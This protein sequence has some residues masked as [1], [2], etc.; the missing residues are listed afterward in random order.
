MSSLRRILSTGLT[1]GREVL[2]SPR[3]R[4]AAEW[5]MPGGRRSDWAVLALVV[6]GVAWSS[7]WLLSKAHPWTVNDIGK[8]ADNGSRKY[9][10]YLAPG[11]WLGSLLHILAWSPLLLFVRWWPRGDAARYAV[12]PR[13]LRPERRAMDPRLFWS[14]LG[15]ILILAA[16]PRWERLGLSYWGDEGWAVTKYSHG[17]WRPEKRDDFQGPMRFWETRWEQAIFDDHTGG[18]HVGFSVA[19]RI[20][21]DAWRAITGRP[22]QD[23][24]ET[25]SRLPS[26]LGGLSSLV[27]LALMF[28]WRGMARTGLV[29]AALLALHPM[30]LR[31]SSEARGYGMMIAL[32][33]FTIWMALIALDTGRWRWWLL[34]GLGECLTMI[35]WRGISYGLVCLNLLLLGMLIFGRAR[36]DTQ[37]LPKGARYVAGGRWLAANLLAG[38]CFLHLSA[39]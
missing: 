29:A 35:T 13:V 37:P 22:R 1:R 9:Q 39:P 2:D 24:S 36:H 14:M 4:R 27:V 26:L 25:V 33:L 23:F 38:G 3:V 32:L 7:W 28:R 8:L 12:R 31:Y 21:M 16:V 19:Q 30:H 18:N 15:I 17:A 6:F 34:F 20:T 10:D 11:L 5:F